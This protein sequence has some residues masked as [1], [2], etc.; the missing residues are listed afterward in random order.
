MMTGAD[1]HD[2]YAILGLDRGCT[3][4]QIRAAYRRLARRHHPDVNADSAEATARLQELNAAYEILW[5]AEQRRIYDR[6]HGGGEDVVP[7]R[8]AGRVERNISQ[9]VNLR[10]EEFLRG[11]ELEVRVNDPANPQGPETY[12]FTVPPD[13]AP[14]E[15]FRLP[16]DEPFRGGFV[17]VRVRARPDY[18]FK[19]RG[20]DLRADLRI[21]ADRAA[22]GGTERIPGATGV[23]VRV[24]IPA[25]VARGAII[26]IPGEGLPKPRGGRGDLLVRIQYRPEVR[27]TRGF[28]SGKSGGLRRLR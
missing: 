4:A 10:I 14:G 19:V 21:S 27:V 5:D 18:R 24:E 6:D 13:T 8:T 26:R 16:R 25:G 20:S 11:A 3:T 9:D 15:R 22:Q 28:G 12:S 23:L 17:I 1:M 2:P 7:P